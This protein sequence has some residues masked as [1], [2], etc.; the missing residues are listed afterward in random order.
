MPDFLTEVLNRPIPKKLWHYTSV[1]GFQGIVTSKGIFATDVRFLNDRTE[2][3]HAREVASQV[4]AE[5]D[6][7]GANFFP[8]KEYS[9]KAVDSAFSTGPLS[10]DRL[11]VF[12]AS[13]SEAE[14]QLSQWRGYSQGSSGVSIAFDLT[15]L[16]RMPRSW[17]PHSSA[18]A[19]PAIT[20][21]RQRR[22]QIMIYQTTAIPPTQA[23]RNWSDLIDPKWKNRVAVAHPAF[24]GYFGQ[25]VLAM[26]KLYGW[27]YFEALAANKPRIGRSG[28]D[29]LTM[30][31]AGESMIGTGPVSTTVQNIEKGNPVNFVYPT[32]GTLLCVGP[33]AVLA[34]APRPNAA[35]LFLEWLLSPDYARACVQ[36]HLEPV[37]ADAP[38]M[39]GTKRLA[40]LKLLRL[41]TEE[42]AT[43]VPEIIEQWR[44]TFGS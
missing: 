21:P 10:A 27:Q 44:D 5:T 39:T 25:W 41:T 32:D 13:F 20:M 2:F 12:V 9:K 14:D 6:E 22:L 3:I 38:L 36:W 30:L 8:A 42:I 40:E 1:Q 16:R 33:S 34:K 35:R 7:Y 43:G 19:R 29:P 4:V 23:P 26:R 31:N 11:Q 28:N 37:R 15:T 17:R 18:S 24:S